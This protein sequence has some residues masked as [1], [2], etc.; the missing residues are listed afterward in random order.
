MLPDAGFLY[1]LLY[2]YIH[3]NF[4]SSLYYNE[5][6]NV[7]TARTIPLLL[8]RMYLHVYIDNQTLRFSLNLLKKEFSYS[9]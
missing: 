5:F 3:L 2:N 8:I 9:T 7:M 1:L 6:K 4:N